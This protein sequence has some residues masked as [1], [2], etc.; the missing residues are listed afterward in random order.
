MVAAALNLTKNAVQQAK[1][2]KQVK[3]DVANFNKLAQNSQFAQFL[4]KVEARSEAEGPDGAVAGLIEY[5]PAG[6]GG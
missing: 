4:A 5:A 3:A 2:S 1:T 6:L